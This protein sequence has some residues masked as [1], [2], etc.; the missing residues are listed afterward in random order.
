M[1]FAKKLFA[2]R[3]N[4]IRHTM[5][6]RHKS[7]VACKYIYTLRHLYYSNN[8]IPSNLIKLENNPT[9]HVIQ[10]WMVKVYLLNVSL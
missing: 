6:L 2:K 10:K 1:S 8:N 9:Y 7:T 4:Y 3:H 5:T